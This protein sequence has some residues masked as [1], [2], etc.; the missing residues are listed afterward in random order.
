MELALP[1]WEELA[2]RLHGS[3]NRAN[4]SVVGSLRGMTIAVLTDWTDTGSARYTRVELAFA[5]PVS[6]RY[7]ISVGAPGGSPDL[8][9]YPDEARELVTML[10]EGAE[11]FSVTTDRLILL[12]PAPLLEPVP[13]V[14]ERL[15]WMV[16]LYQALGHGG[17]PYR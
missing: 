14:T 10:I 4:M 12:L 13:F 3:L 9:S 15:E 2:G 17:G 7:A 8:T 16:Q 6:G 11:G 1:R 5:M